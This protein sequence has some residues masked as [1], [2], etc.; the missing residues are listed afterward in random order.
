M[1]EKVY[2]I[3]L[4]ALVSAF[5]SLIICGVVLISVQKPSVELPEVLSLKSL[6]V[7]DS[8]T[9]PSI[10]DVSDSVVLRNDGVI[11][12]K[13]KIVADH[14]MGTQFSGRYLVGKRLLVSSNDPISVASPNSLEFLAELGINSE[15]NSG[16]LLI[17]SQNGG[18]IIGVGPK[19]GQCVYLGFENG[20]SFDFSIKNNVNGSQVA[21]LEPESNLKNEATST[22]DLLHSDSAPPYAGQNK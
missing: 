6:T 5:V 22:P 11:F 16:E 13:G 2:S 21:L 20:N 17:R 9:I 19:S 4:N 14:F 7:T 3:T 12:S 18:N 1:K 8:I 10:D 15:T